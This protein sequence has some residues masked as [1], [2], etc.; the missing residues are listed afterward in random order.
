MTQDQHKLEPCPFCGGEASFGRTGTHRRSC[1]VTCSE[2]GA[3]LESS[4]EYER[5][6][7]AWNRRAHLQQRPPPEHVEHVASQ[8]DGC[9]YDAGPG[10]YIDIGEAIRTAFG[11]ARDMETL[12]GRPLPVREGSHRWNIERDGDDLL[13]CFDLHDK[14]QPCEYE[15]FVRSPSL[16]VRQEPT[17]EQ[18]EAGARVLYQDATSLGD[19][20]WGRKWARRVYEA[21]LSA[22]PSVQNMGEGETGKDGVAIPLAGQ[23][24]EGGE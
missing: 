3:T 6:G 21:M 1:I 14:G 19:V 4:D 7:A 8:W 11:F 20:G 2:C 22:S 16:P 12:S 24:Q 23:R 5:S 15:R 13:V 9:M 17:D 18:I 10:G